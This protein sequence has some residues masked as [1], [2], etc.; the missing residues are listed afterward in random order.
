[1]SALMGVQTFSTCWIG[2]PGKK[3]IYRASS[4]LSKMMHFKMAGGT[5]LRTLL[6]RLSALQVMGQLM[7]YMIGGSP[8]TYLQECMW[9]KGLI[10]IS[11][12][13]R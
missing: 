6:Q 3:I 7:E 5:A 12:Q 4:A 11:S 1:M 8:V 13:L 2:W 9:M 10:V